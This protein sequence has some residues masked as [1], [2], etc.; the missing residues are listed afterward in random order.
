M[1]IQKVRANDRFIE[2]L[3][4]GWI[5]ANQRYVELLNR[6]DC[7]WW[8]NERT[9]VSVLAGAAWS[10]G[11]AAIEEYPSGKKRKGD[12]GEKPDNNTSKGR[13]DL[14]IKSELESIAV[15]A[16]HVW[17][18]LDSS[19]N[20]IKAKIGLGR[21]RDDAKRLNDQA[22]RHFAATFI[23]FNTKKKLDER[24][25]EERITATINNAIEN[26]DIDSI[27]YAYLID[28]KSAFMNHKNKYYQ[29]VALIL[30]QI[31]IK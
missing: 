26:L 24:T 30:E 3:L 28:N 21:A 25:L 10:L 9:N 13:V 2:E 14:Y 11:W 12:T 15:E 23:V 7:C 17:L 8:Y 1:V 27:A 29:S 16:K 4:N 6:T 19:I 20:I 22:G 5:S 31:E 18:N